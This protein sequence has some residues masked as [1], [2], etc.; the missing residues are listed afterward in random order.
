[1][2]FQAGCVDAIGTA[3]VGSIVLTVSMDVERD[4]L[5]ADGSTSVEEVVESVVKGEAGVSESWTAVGEVVVGSVGVV[6]AEVSIVSVGVVV[7]VGEEDGDSET[8]RVVVVVAE[9]CSL[10]MGTTM[11]TVS[12][13]TEAGWVAVD[14]VVTVVVVAGWC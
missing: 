3:E 10:W 2:P 8:T 11:T 1:M 6:T 5:A 14:V 7:V 9:F 13:A 12:V 4:G